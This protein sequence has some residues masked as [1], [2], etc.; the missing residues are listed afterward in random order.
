MAL[1]LA[2][3]RIVSAALLRVCDRSTFFATLALFARVDISA[4]VPTAATDGRD[5]FIN[6]EFFGAL[7][8]AE[9][10]AVLLHEVLHAALLH[11]PRRGSRDPQLWNV[12]A[13]I[14]VNG[15][16]A[17]EG[18]TLPDGALRDPSNEHF[19]TEEVYDLLMQSAQQP[20]P[21]PWNDLL[22]ARP[23][24]ASLPADAGVPSEKE[25]DQQGRSAALESYW[26]DAQQQARMIAESS[27]A[28]MLP[29]GLNRELGSLSEARI[30]WRSYLWRYLV[31][32]PNDFT[33]FDRRFVGQ[34]LYL[35]AL[36]GESV[37]VHVAVDTSG[38]I[39]PRALDV[40]LSEVRAILHAYP[41]LRCDLYYADSSLH[42]PFPLTPGGPV[43]PPIGG[44]GTSF[45]PFF[46]RLEMQ[47]DGWTATVAVY[48]TDGYGDFPMTAPSD[49]VLW[50]V[51]PGGLDV[52][53]FPFGEAVRL[54]EHIDGYNT[55]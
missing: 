36:T 55:V 29:A 44:G 27:Q 7:K 32:T 28:G 50:V 26:R 10:D 3:S 42:G 25:S 37:H 47:R 16:I 11:V 40:F 51:T 21:A 46:E 23:D 33:G 22:D 15:M 35:E 49:P 34:G 5:I 14:V 12:A 19:S 39:N 41:H 4:R 31:Q 1:D 18:Y 8:P 54:S 30:D 52:A 13:D 17:K 53:R 2:T 6:P 38:S 9:Q 20:A 45:R 43:P 24:D 48:L